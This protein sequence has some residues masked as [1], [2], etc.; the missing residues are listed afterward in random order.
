M[1]KTKKY[2]NYTIV[3]RTNLSKINDREKK[4][5]ELMKEL[6]LKEKDEK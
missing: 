5:N 6:E 2:Q 3:S 4:L 1:M